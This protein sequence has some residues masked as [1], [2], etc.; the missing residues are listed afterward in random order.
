MTSILSILGQAATRPTADPLMDRATLIVLAGWGVVAL[1]LAVVTGVFRRGSVVGPARLGER[2]ALAPLLSS[3]FIGVGVWVAVPMFMLGVPTKPAGAPTTAASQPT[4]APANPVAP[5]APAYPPDK[6]V[7]VNLAASLA[8]CAAMLV[9]YLAMRHQAGGA[10]RGAGLGLTPTDVRTGVWRGAVG[11]VMMT[12]L[13]FGVSIAS[14]AVYRR[15]GY[16][17]PKEHD[18]LRMLGESRSLLWSAMFIASAVVVAPLF[19]EI[20]FRGHLQT[21]LAGALGR[22]GLTATGPA[23]EVRNPPA[24]DASPVLSYASPAPAPAVVRPSAVARWLAI[25]VTSVLF[26]WI[27]PVW[28]IPP[29]FVLSLCIGYAY[30]RTGNLWVAITMH[31]L[32]NTTSTVLFLTTRT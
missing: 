20:L 6:L 21:L 28:T 32:F 12:W 11:A 3:M 27:H 16:T 5:A 9:S 1:G 22:L 17:H 23:E 13:V 10:P 18:L 4:V 14:E 15:V 30:E 2:H 7:T 25:F 31:A 29:I 24:F 19:E 26:A 8:A